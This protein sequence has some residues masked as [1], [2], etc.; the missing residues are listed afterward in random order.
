MLSLLPSIDR[1]LL[2]EA[3]RLKGQVATIA[4]V[5]A[6]G[7]ASFVGLRG[8]YAS[9]ERSRIAYYERYRF[10]DVFVSLERAPLAVA[11]RIEALPGVALIESRIVREVSLPIEGMGRP[12][13]GRLVSLPAGREPALNALFL[14]SGR[15]PE[16][17]RE[18]E[19]L[20]LSSFAT[21]HGLQPGHRI[22]AVING[23]LRQ[24][25]VVGTVLSPEF[26]YA[27]RPGAFSDDP[28]RYAV[29]WMNR[30]PLAAAFALEGAFNDLS[31]RLQ[32]GAV[33]AEVCAAIDRLLAPYG[34]NGAI[35]RRDQPSNKILTGEL[36]QLSALAG[37]VPIIFL[38]VGAFLVN[39]VLG[40]LIALQ[41]TEIAALKA[42]GYT[43]RELRR[44][45]LGLVALVLVP[46]IA[47][48]VFG[49]LGL[50]HLVVGLYASV[51]RFPE[52]VFS[53]S[54]SLVLVGATI[55]ATAAGAGALLAVRAAVRLPPAEA[56]RPPAPA[57]YRRGFLERLG[58]GGLAGPTGMMVIREVQRRPL[59]TLF[60]AVGIAGAVALVIL[61]RFGIDSLDSYLEGSLRREQ[62]HDLSVSFM[63]PVS[64]RVLRELGAMPG[65]LRA[66]S[67][68]ALPVRIRHEHRSRDSVIIALAD[69]ASLRRLIERDGRVLDVPRDGVLMTDKL[70]EVLGI[71]IGDRPELE[72]REGARP[73]VLP[74]VAGFVKD[75]IGLQIYA[76]QG[77]IA[78]LVREEGPVSSV[79][80]S[81]DP[82][83]RAGIEERLRRA[84]TVVDVSDLK[85]DV[86][87]L[88]DMNASIMDIWTAVS[89]S[90]AAAVIFGVVYNNARISLAA[91]SRDLASLRVLGFS[92]R[93]ISTI[94]IAGLSV[95]VALAIPIGLWLGRLWA[96]AFMK[97]V[98]QET[99]RWAVWIAPSTYLLAAAVAIC[100]AALSALWVRRSLDRLDL[101]GVLKTRE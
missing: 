43:N 23:K 45:Y 51:F 93:E 26:V 74:V 20:V 38:G 6:C 90:L 75:S 47:L 59:R 28:K 68:R 58:V 99:F 96:V 80:L 27:L 50:G 78:T 61:G 49:G 76:R 97:S 32:P 39:L 36:Q 44:H 52:L 5:L 66:E 29:V 24:L 56:M 35:E 33:A 98:D 82:A 67:M 101:I 10:A 72:I 100:A 89:I 31:L 79:L 91:R 7:I 70:A 95:E 21:A 11:R 16:P 37:M 13:S 73:R 8:T 53:L 85:A 86:A 42:V 46:G 22:P 14:R 40:R 60:S 94:L 57:H 71:Q 88:R 9:L 77:L 65:V 1:K 3:R 64:D 18:D 84:P 92:I 54:P 30:A 62:R 83:L 63:R 2:R 25:R 19:V 41:R 69:D 12:A 81:V 55:S 48:G 17:D 4:V 34:G 87:R 15:Y